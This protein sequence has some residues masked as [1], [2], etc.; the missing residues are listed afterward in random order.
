ML[1]HIY[2]L[3]G[4]LVFILHI[5][6]IELL[7]VTQMPRVDIFLAVRISDLINC[8]SHVAGK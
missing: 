5:I 3:L 6:K 1:I 2:F 8:A 7:S 4:L